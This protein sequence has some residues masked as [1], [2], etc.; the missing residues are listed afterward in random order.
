MIVY[1]C[2]DVTAA[3]DGTAA[4]VRIG[5]G[6]PIAGGLLAGHDPMSAAVGNVAELLDVD[7]DQ[8]VGTR[9]FVAADDLTGGPVRPAQPVQ[10]VAGQDAVDRRAG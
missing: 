9:S 3:D 2:V 1:G 6:L 4:P 10:A 8:F 5:G 7:V